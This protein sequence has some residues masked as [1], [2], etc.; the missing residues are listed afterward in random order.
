MWNTIGEP[1][2]VPYGDIKSAEY[3]EAYGNT[4]KLSEVLQV[5][6]D[7]RTCEVSWRMII[8]I[9]EEPPIEKKHITDIIYQFI[10]RPE[11]Q[12]IFLSVW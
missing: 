6:I 9:V 3:I 8:T 4:I 1:L 10:S 11:I 5:W 2:E 7:K 12:N